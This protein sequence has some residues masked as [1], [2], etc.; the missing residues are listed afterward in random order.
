MKWGRQIPAPTSPDVLE[1]LKVIALVLQDLDAKVASLHAKVT[2][3]S[4]V[5]EGLNRDR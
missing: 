2:V 5:Y 3:I 1:A 4:D